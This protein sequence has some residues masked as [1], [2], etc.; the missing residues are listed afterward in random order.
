MDTTTIRGLPSELKDLAPF[1]P[2]YGKDEDGEYAEITVPDYFP[3]G[4]IAVFKT[5]MPDTD[6]ELEATC[7][8]NADE[9][10]K[11]LD[12]IDL[13][14]LLYRANSEENDVTAGEIGA[15]NVPDMG[16]LTYCGLQGWMAA[17]NYVMSHNDLG[18]PLCN[19]LRKGTWAMDYVSNRLERQLELFPRLDGPAKWFKERFDKIKTTVPNF[20]RP[21]YFAVVIY[22]AYQAAVKAALEQ[23]SEFVTN[24]HEFTKALAMTALQMHGTVISASID[25][26][27][28]VPS[29]AAGLPHFATGWG[30]TWGRDAAISLRG[31]FLTTGMF[32]PARRH[33]LALMSLVKHGLIP[34]LV[35]SCRTPRYNSRDSPWWMLINIQEYVKMAPNG[36]AILGENIKR[37]FP[38]DGTWVAWDDARAF[39]E[40][41]TLAEL[42]QDIVQGHAR[43]IHFREHNAGPKLDSQMRDEGFNLDIEV[44]WKTGLVHGGNSFNCG[45][46][47]DKNGESEKAGTKGIPGSPRDGAPVEIQGMLKAT[48]RWLADLSSR[49]QFPFNGVNAIGKC[50]AWNFGTIIDSLDSQR[51]G[52]VCCV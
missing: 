52:E 37:R 16:D 20:L 31:L 22:A 19:H 25:P 46:W 18:H 14:V 17:L 50:S 47:M 33:I 48:L 34:N 26:A 35:D 5:H 11:E 38:A 49:G 39:S 36:L 2:S 6:P 10:V 13:N 43:G 4:S 32:E 42:I 40:T 15:Y 7:R 51:R 1:A 30:R 21:K 45:T 41:A 24:G 9:M 29:L 23:Q 27:I 12:L 44:D 8:A 28:P 3:P